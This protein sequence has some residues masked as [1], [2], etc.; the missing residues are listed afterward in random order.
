MMKKITRTWPV[1]FSVLLLL[2]SVTVSASAQG[3]FVEGEIRWKK[4][5]GVAPARPGDSKPTAS[6]CQIFSVAALVNGRK[7]VASTNQGESPFLRADEKDYYVCRYSLKVPEGGRLHIAPGIAGITGPWIDGSQ[8]TPPAGYKRGFLGA[9]YVTLSGGDTSKRTVQTANFEMTY[10]EGPRAFFAGAW[11]AK[12][13]EG[14]LEL[15]FQQ[16][17]DEVTGQVKINSADVGVIKEG[18]VFANTLRFK[19]VRA[20]RAL[21]NGANLPDA[22]VGTGELVM[23]AGGKSFTGNV[24]GT[25][26]SGGTFI[27]R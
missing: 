26:T 3:Y 6:P 12:L 25:A 1:V 24:L 17:G 18:I 4:E 22:F 21:G 10:V 19:I 2:V 16:I 9:T 11:R 7:L 27:G 23:D 8:S 14:A 13:G 20:G 5:M 15:I